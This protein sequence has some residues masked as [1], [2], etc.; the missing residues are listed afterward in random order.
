MAQSIGE[1][2]FIRV[3]HVRFPYWITLILGTLAITAG[4]G[5]G[6]DASRRDLEALRQEVAELKSAQARMQATLESLQTTLA[7]AR[8]TNT[9]EPPRAV[10]GAAAP[11]AAAD[12]E[13]APPP[14]DDRQAIVAIPLESAPRKGAPSAPV[15]VVEFADFQCPFCKANAGF[16]DQLIRKFP[17]Q[18]QFVFKHYPIGKHSMAQEAARAAWAA[19][20]QGKFWEMHDLLYGSEQTTFSPEVLRGFAEQLGL[21]MPRFEA[22]YASARGAFAVAADKKLGK[23]VRIHGTPTYFVNGKRVGNPSM[24]AALAMVKQELAAFR[25]G[26]APPDESLEAPADSGASANGS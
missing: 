3:A 21:D 7:K 9:A 15:T 17:G 13:P 16:S 18:V 5:C 8:P 23:Q 14:G 20:Q 10:D 4:A 12:A 11:T 24:I 26:D 19:Q 1:R 6:D 22:D 25:Q 2:R